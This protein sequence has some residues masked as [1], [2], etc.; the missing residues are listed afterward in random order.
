ME[1]HYIVIESQN[2]VLRQ[3]MDMPARTEDA[4]VA[5]V[6]R[7]AASTWT[8]ADVEVL[9]TATVTIGEENAVLVAREH[10]SQDR[11]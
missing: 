6:L 4:R 1:R 11:A 7:R 5:K 2:V 8:D 3:S 10:A 9:T